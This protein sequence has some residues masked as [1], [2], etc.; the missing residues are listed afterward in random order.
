MFISIKYPEPYTCL[1]QSNNLNL[2]KKFIIL[3]IIIKQLY[4]SWV[5]NPNYT[6]FLR[7]RSIEV[8]GK[9]WIINNKYLPELFLHRKSKYHLSHQPK[10]WVSPA[11][12]WSYRNNFE[13]EVQLI[14]TTFKYLHTV[15]ILV[16]DQ[17]MQDFC[18]SGLRNPTT[19]IIHYSH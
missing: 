5:M 15:L 18:N 1:Y 9:R 14:T 4:T 19:R 17:M 16:L 6:H 3:M 11:K 7:S 8:K 2:I 12:P 10:F 13:E